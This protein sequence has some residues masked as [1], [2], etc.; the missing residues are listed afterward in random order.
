MTASGRASWSRRPRAGSRRSTPSSHGRPRSGLRRRRAGGPRG[1]RAGA[2]PAERLLLLVTGPLLA[3]SCG[4]S[5]RARGAAR[6]QWADL[7]QL[8][9]LL[10]DALRVLPTLV[11]YGRGPS[12][13]RWLSDVS[14]SY[15]V[16]T[17]RVLR[18]AFLS[19][20][21][22]E[23]GATLCT[24]L[25]AVTVGV[26]VFEG[27]LGLERALLV[28][29][30]TPEFFAPLRSLG[31]D[32]HAGLE[33][34]P[35]AERV[36]ALLDLPEPVRGTAPAPAGVP[37]LRLAGVAVR[38]GDRTVLTGVDL[39]LPP[40]SR[41]ALV[42]PERSGQDEPRPPAARLAVPDDGRG[43]GRRSAADRARP[44]RLAGPRRLRARAAV[45]AARDGG[46]QRAGSGGRRRPTRRSRRAAAAHVLDVVRRLPQGRRHPAG[47]GRRRLSGGERLRI[48]IAR[49]FVKD[50]A[51][52]VLDEPTAQLDAD[53]EARC[54]SRWTSW[55]GAGPS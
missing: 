23:L 39:D 2:G 43:A 16:A 6:R 41:T 17:M 27:D 54:S 10:V 30:L 35:A 1:H 36:F 22:L 34:R 18:S 44:R 37:H 12:S 20:F 8:G 38:H 51:V 55:R 9:A 5:G 52:L 13:V 14:E 24:A 46:G 32:H 11:A 31:A 42:G 7:G 25:V 53:A 29:L 19:G 50:A 49:A 40:R 48:A 45:A 3:S 28:L 26:R 15:R 33:G 21:V 47:G 4:S